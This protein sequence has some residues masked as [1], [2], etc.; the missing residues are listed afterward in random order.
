MLSCPSLGGPQTVTATTTTTNVNPSTC[1]TPA[2]IAV[3]WILQPGENNQFAQFA[4]PTCAATYTTNTQL[5]LG[6]I[7]IASTTLSYTTL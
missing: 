5:S 4:T 1:P 3:D 7:N 6:G 2:P